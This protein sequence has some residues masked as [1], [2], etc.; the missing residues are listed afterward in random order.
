MGHA[1]FEEGKEW[2]F[3]LECATVVRMPEPL[4]G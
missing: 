3:R 1:I 4:M 2:A